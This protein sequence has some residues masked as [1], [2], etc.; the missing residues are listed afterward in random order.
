LVREKRPRLF[1]DGQNIHRW[2]GDLMDPNGQGEWRACH[3]PPAL[4]AFRPAGLC[5]NIG[6]EGWEGG[7]GGQGPGRFS[8]IGGKN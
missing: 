6:A 4:R 7:P 1:P 5:G 2:G 8:L 3:G